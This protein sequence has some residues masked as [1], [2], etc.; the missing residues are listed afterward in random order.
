MKPDR[1]VLRETGRLAV[2]VLI[3]ALVMLGV[4]AVLGRL[5]AAVALGG[6]YT[7]LLTVVNFFLMGLTVQGITGRAAEKQRDE[8]EMAAISK[9]MEN[10]MKFSRSMRMVG[11]FGLIVLGITVFKF[12]ALPTILPIVFP[13]VVIRVMQ[14]IDM[15]SSGSKG[16]E[17]P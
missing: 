15:K 14:I 12:E 2:G 1:E 5:S 3:M 7:S 8:Q 17:K 6:L 13:T 4:Y 16:S 9:E 11:L 10:R